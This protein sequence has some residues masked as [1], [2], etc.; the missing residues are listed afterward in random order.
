MVNI[1]GITATEEY[2]II[3]KKYDIQLSYKYD[4]IDKILLIGGIL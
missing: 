1:K 3:L 4:I 2:K